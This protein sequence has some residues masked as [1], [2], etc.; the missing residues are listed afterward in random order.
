MF[1]GILCLGLLPFAACAVDDDKGD[2]SELPDFG[3]DDSFQRPTDHG[4]IGF[5][6]PATSE[7]TSSEKFHA[8]TFELSNEAR[9]E[10]ATSYAVLGQRRT[11][12]VLYLYKQGPTGTWGPYVVRNDD[13]GDSVYSRITRELDAGRYRL[14][15]KG[16]AATTKGKF[17]LTV[18]CEGPG[19]AP[20]PTGC[21]FGST[22]GE[23]AGNPAL[24][25][26]NRNV[27]TAATLATLSAEDRAHLVIAVQQSSHTDVTTAE[28]ALARVDQEEMNVTWFSE[29]AARR[30]FVAFEY[31]A[32]DN[33]YGA[34]FDR[35][36][37]AMVTDIHDGDLLSCQLPAETC[38]LPEDY[39]A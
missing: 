37:G 18:D 7:L 25:I 36:T 29:T 10:M 34:I 26:N 3:K 22:Y 28:E 31:G 15:V 24:V 12:T 23:I 5:A 27:I 4:A 35:Y 16:Y 30:T 11:D 20:T 6:A 33:S 14:I 39:T 1:H 8:W 19:C 13:F 2:E 21:V 9:L 17:K 38:L 32:G